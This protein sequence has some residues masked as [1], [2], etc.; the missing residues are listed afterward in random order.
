M[1]EEEN[2]NA[3][4]QSNNEASHITPE[5]SL[6]DP[7]KPWRDQIT[8]HHLDFIGSVARLF[9][10]WQTS[11][12]TETDIV[13]F[14]ATLDRLSTAYDA[15]KTERTEATVATPSKQFLKPNNFEALVTATEAS[16]T[17]ATEPLFPNPT[18]ASG[19]NEISQILQILSNNQPDRKPISLYQ[20]TQLLHES[21]QIEYNTLLAQ[22]THDLVLPLTTLRGYAGFIISTTNGQATLKPDTDVHISIPKLKNLITQSGKTIQLILPE[23]L[24]TLAGERLPQ[25]IPSNI[26]I[27][28]LPPRLI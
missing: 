26:L 13:T 1:I 10:M 4:S 8:I 25:Q 6:L 11:P 7:L 23:C 20:I 12:Q 5:P 24:S 27:Q 21:S 22:A 9:A 28:T 2:N 17:K 18:I 16:L 3:H 19:V 14:L 15:V